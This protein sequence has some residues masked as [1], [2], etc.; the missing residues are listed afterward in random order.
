MVLSNS[1]NKRMLILKH[2]LPKTDSININYHNFIILFFYLFKLC[3]TKSFHTK[4][5]GY[6]TFVLYLEIY[7][8]AKSKLN[9]WKIV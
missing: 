3:K 7:F 6:L 4:K 5:H 2:S 8:F 9:F 1:E